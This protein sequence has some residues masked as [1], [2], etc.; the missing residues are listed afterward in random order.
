MSN[1]KEMVDQMDEL[2]SMKDARD[3]LQYRIEDKVKKA[4]QVREVSAK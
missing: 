2:D 1:W 4:N 3:Y